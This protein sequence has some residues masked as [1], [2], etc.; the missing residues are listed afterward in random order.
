M[1]I[2][3]FSFEYNYI[4]DLLLFW[5]NLVYMGNQ[6]NQN[7]KSSLQFIKKFQLGWL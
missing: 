1:N 4:V 7:L 3:N 5:F 2:W 6:L